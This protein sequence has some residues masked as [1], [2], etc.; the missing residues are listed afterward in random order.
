MVTFY[1]SISIVDADNSMRTVPLNPD[2][3]FYDSVLRDP[4]ELSNNSGSF[5]LEGVD[6]ETFQ[7]SVLE[8]ADFGA[9]LG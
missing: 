9:S 3:T 5:N 2:G 4:L 8:M 1:D 7:D 6:G